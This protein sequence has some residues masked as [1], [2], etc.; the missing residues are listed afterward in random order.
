MADESSMWSSACQYVGDYVVEGWNG[1]WAVQVYKHVD[2]I[3]MI[4]KDGV[5]QRVS[6][7]VYNSLNPQI[8]H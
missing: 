8:I 7:R 5:Q 3:L 1:Q 2:Y 6:H 4:Y